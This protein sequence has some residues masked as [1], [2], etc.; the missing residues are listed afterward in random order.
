[1]HD[2]LI[3]HAENPTATFKVGI[4]PIERD[5]VGYRDHN[6]ERGP[7]PYPAFEGGRIDANTAT[8]FHVIFTD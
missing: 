1:M 5:R 4:I 8:I 2:P 3:A 6:S 7:R